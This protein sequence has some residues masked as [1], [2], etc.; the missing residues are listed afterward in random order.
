MSIKKNI[1]LGIGSY[2]MDN[3][4]NLPSLPDLAWFDKQMGQ[5]TNSAEF[6]AIPLPCV[7]MEF[8]QF[9]W[10][11]VGNNQQ[12]GTGNIR[13]YTYFENYANSFTGSVDQEMALR[14]FEF[15]EQLNMLLQG[16]TL[17]GMAPLERVGDNEDNAQDMVITSWIDYATIIT[18]VSTDANRHAT[19]TT[20]EVK[21]TKRDTSSRPVV[22][23]NKGFII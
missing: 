11:T 20:S 21:I 1:Y 6:Y 23:G 17:A 2:L 18:D 22:D 5:F 19:L 12:R 14:F 16:Y 13:F 7:L 15:T 10:Q 8:Q 9:S 4:K 3:L